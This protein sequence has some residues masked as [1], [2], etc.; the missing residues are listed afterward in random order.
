MHYILCNPR[1]FDERPIKRHKPTPVQNTTPAIIKTSTPTSI[2]N[3]DNNLVHE[4]QSQDVAPDTYSATTKQLVQAALTASRTHGSIEVLQLIISCIQKLHDSSPVL[5][6]GIKAL[7]EVYKSLIWAR[8]PNTP[9]TSEYSVSPLDVNGVPK[10]DHG[11]SFGSTTVSHAS[12]PG[13]IS[14]ATSFTTDTVLNDLHTKN[15]GNSAKTIT[16]VPN[17]FA[18]E[19]IRLASVYDAK[20]PRTWIGV[21]GLVI[22]LTE[23]ATQASSIPSPA[24]SYQKPT[25]VQ[26]TRLLPENVCRDMVRRAWQELLVAL[27]RDWSQPSSNANGHI[28][29]W[30]PCLEST[31]Q[32]LDCYLGKRTDQ[33]GQ[34]L[35]S[36]FALAQELDPGIVVS[37][38]RI[39][40]REMQII[41]D[42]CVG[43]KR[44]LGRILFPP[45]ASWPLI[46]HASR[47]HT[48]KH[49]YDQP[50]YSCV[51][52][53][54]TWDEIEHGPS[55]DKY[56]SDLLFQRAS[57]DEIVSATYNHSTI[58]RGIVEAE[59]KRNHIYFCHSPS[60]VVE[61]GQERPGITLPNFN[62]GP[63]EEGK[64]ISQVL[65]E[66]IAKKAST[67]VEHIQSI[68]EFK[69]P[70]K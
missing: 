47:A 34:Y 12:Q 10:L 29:S 14:S 22:Y 45:D 41:V 30:Q 42:L 61:K 67:V 68:C 38:G 21:I 31:L 51:R 27:D 4:S 24:A 55:A 40:S 53:T 1:I 19:Y 50:Q 56:V 62:L 33:N 35:L 17:T 54:L 16:S 15:D 66:A 36:H 44:R 7:Q 9:I 49:V 48:E 3:D 6:V 18:E 23:L 46:S 63:G 8:L 2:P 11:T 28:H 65:L 20:R 52:E 39:L 37:E 25:L 69:I 13:N 70:S 58:K 57:M 5:D 32:L 26:E 60:S 64:L 43:R 59:I